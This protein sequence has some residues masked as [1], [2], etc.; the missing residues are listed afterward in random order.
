LLRCCSF[1]FRRG[2]VVHP[3]RLQ[4]SF[5]CGELLALGGCERDRQRGAEGGLEQLSGGFTQRVLEYHSQLI[6]HVCSSFQIV[7]SVTWTIDVKFPSPFLDMTRFLSLFSFDFLSLECMFEKSD[8]FLSVYVWSVAPLCV[9]M[10]LLIV[11]ALRR[12]VS[13]AEGAKV[14]TR[15]SNLAN[16]LLLLGYL[17]LLRCLSSNC[18]G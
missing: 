15:A 13:P 16:R 6:L 8:H 12:V 17:V 4:A 3:S 9:A 10:V 2:V 7:Q 11:Y 5:F 1:S 18:K 14:S